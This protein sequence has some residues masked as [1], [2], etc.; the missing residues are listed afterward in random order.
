MTKTAAQLDD[1]V[2]EAI[3][4]ERNAHLPEP[5]TMQPA[6][7]NA[8]L[9]QLGKKSSKIGEKLIAAGRGYEKYWDTM[10]KT[11]PLAIEFR[12]V[13]DRE[14]ALR[15]EITRRMGPGSTSRLPRGF[16]PIRSW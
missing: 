3:C 12:V 10:A 9:D 8:E 14:R 11:D 6:K 5:A 2:A 15:H 4:K 7:I 13:A 16:G 1:D